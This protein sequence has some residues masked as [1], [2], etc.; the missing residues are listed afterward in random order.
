MTEDQLKE[1]FAEF[2]EVISTKIIM[3]KFS[4]R[5]KGFGFVELEE[6]ESASKAMET[7]NGK[8]VNGRNIIVNEARPP[9]ERPAY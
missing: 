7:L 8:E 6:K 5:S 3:D 2:G 1:V 4:G 9:K